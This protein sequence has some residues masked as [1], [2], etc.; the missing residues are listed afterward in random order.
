MINLKKV[1]AVTLMASML[2]FTGCSKKDEVALKVGDEQVSYDLYN[3]YLAVYENVTKAQYGEE[4]FN[5]EVEGKTLSDLLKDNLVEMLSTQTMIESYMT[6]NGYK[7]DEAKIKEEITKL[8]ASLDSQPQMKEIYTASK[9]T[10][11]FYDEQVRG[12]LLNEAFNDHL[13]KQVE[14][15]EAYK[16]KIDEAF[17]S[18]VY[19]KARH[20]L[21]KGEGEALKLRG[22][23][24]QGFDT[25]ENYASIHSLDPGSKVK[26]GD[27]GY[28]ARGQMV[29]AFDE[30]AFTLEVGK[31]SEPI[32]TDFGYHLI[33]V[34]DKKTIQEMMDGGVEAAVVD[35]LKEAI[36]YP[37]MGEEYD[38]ILTSLKEKYKVENFIA[39]L[40]AKYAPKEE[41]KE[42]AKEEV[43][44]DAKAEGD[45]EAADDKSTDSAEKKDN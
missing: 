21:V 31:I 30:A 42:D 34:E 26:G 7:A 29:P 11:A 16:A 25:F 44:E 4:A 8:K 40:D 12:T 41:K 14:T 1:V 27:L 28:F 5:Q 6:E 37:Y 20:I 15:G 33:L 9:V 32:Q 2:L 18:E 38:K 36:L 19:V 22:E 39:E 10:D 43:K 45:A 13:K 24:E 17:N 23:L 35:P 3:Q